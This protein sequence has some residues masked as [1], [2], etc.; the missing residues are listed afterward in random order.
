MQLHKLENMINES[1]NIVALLGPGILEECG[2]PNFRND[3]SSYEVE[4]KYGYSPT[5]LLSAQFYET[6]KE[7]FFEYYK[8]IILQ[9]GVPCQALYTLSKLEETGKLKSIITTNMYNIEEEAGCK[10]VIHLYGYVENNKCPHCGTAYPIS[11]IKDAKNV[12]L[13]EKCQVAIRPQILLIG[14]RLD[15]GL[16]T[17]ATNAIEQ[18]DMLLLLGTHIND[19]R[20][21]NL[22]QYYTGNRLVVINDIIHCADSNADILIKDRP[23]NVLPKINF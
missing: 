2:L 14:E 19:Y 10:N 12:P 18:A 21:G 6:R 1:N 9:E 15:N 23:S 20:T 7:L 22:I 17:Q 3:D 16:I 13:C 11:Y 5:E 4:S 8:E